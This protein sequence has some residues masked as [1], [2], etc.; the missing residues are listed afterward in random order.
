MGTTQLINYLPWMDHTAAL[1]YVTMEYRIPN[2]NSSY[3]AVYTGIDWQTEANIRELPGFLFL[4]ILTVSI[5][6]YVHSVRL[7]AEII[8]T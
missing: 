7:S 6:I 3:I 1:P 2:R 5:H 4:N 8:Y